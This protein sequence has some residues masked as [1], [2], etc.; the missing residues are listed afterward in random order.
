[1]GRRLGELRSLVAC[2]YA[3]ESLAEGSRLLIWRGIGWCGQ[4]PDPAS[5]RGRLYMLGGGVLV[6]GYG[7]VRYPMPGVALELVGWCVA[8]WMHAPQAGADVGEE[9]LLDD[10]GE[11]DEPEPA[12]PLPGIL[13]ELIGDAPGVHLPTIVAHL[14]ETGLDTTCDRAS[15]RAAITRRGIPLRGS[16]RAGGRVNEG[17]HRADLQTWIAAHSP[18]GPTGQAKTRSDTATTGLTCD[19]ADPATAVAAPPTPH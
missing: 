5:S 3:I 13:Q 8:A 12:D 10:P 15:V 2:R 7:A 16:V 19:V 11:D 14:H 1:M 4:A 17:V 9:E 18:T 6:A